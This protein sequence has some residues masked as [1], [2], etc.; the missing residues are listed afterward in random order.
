MEKTGFLE[1]APG[2]KSI[3]RLAFIII[4]LFACFMCGWLVIAHNNY[5]GG[6][7]VFSSITTFATGLKIIQTNQEKNNGTVQRTK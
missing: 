6:I 3:M 4:V 2:N 1:V 7:V 5:T